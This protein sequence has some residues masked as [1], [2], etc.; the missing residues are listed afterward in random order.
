MRYFL[1]QVNH[2]IKGIYNFLQAMYTIPTLITTM[3]R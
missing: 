1:S 3:A 2:L